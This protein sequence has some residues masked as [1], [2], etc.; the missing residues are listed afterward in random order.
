MY[1]REMKSQPK[2]IREMSWNGEKLEDTFLLLTYH[3]K[4]K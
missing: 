2:V 1:C 4:M 3:E